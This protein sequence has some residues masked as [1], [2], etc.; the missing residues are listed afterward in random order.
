MLEIVGGAEIQ[1]PAAL[2]DLFGVTKQ[3]AAVH[4]SRA[5]ELWRM[6]KSDNDTSFLTT[7]EDLQQ[8]GD[9][10]AQLYELVQSVMK[11]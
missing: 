2:D 10:Q 4:F 8:A 5:M 6:T 3:Q 1:F 9:T 11:T 7:L